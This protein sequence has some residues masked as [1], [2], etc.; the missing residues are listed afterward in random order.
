ML[1]NVNV[2]F[3]QDTFCCC[4]VIIT[5]SFQ[6]CTC[7]RIHLLF[8]LWL[9]HFNIM[10]VLGCHTEQF[11]RLGNVGETFGDGMNH[12]HVAFS[13]HIGII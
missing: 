3:C 7:T 8:C 10:H 6:Q 4:C 11:R 12:I 13:K 2:H 9:K 1:K 5:S